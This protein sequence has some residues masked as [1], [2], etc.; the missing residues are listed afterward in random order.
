MSN[1]GEQ[2]FNEY[3]ERYFLAEI[4]KNSNLPSIALLQIIRDTGVEPAWTQI[5]LPTGRSVAACQNAYSAL[6]QR[7]SS[8]TGE[9]VHKKPRR[10]PSF[11]GPPPVTERFLQPRPAGFAPVNGPELVSLTTDETKPRKKRGRPNK[12]EHDRRVA[13]AEARGEVYPKPRKPKT[14]RPATEGQEVETV[15]VSGSGAPMAI[16]FTPNKTVPAPPT[17]P[18]PGEKMP[19]YDAIE[20]AAT[21]AGRVSHEEQRSIESAPAEPRMNN[22]G[23]GENVLPGLR[24]HTITTEG[25]DIEMD[26]SAPAAS[27]ALVPVGRV[28]GA[29]QVHPFSASTAQEPQAQLIRIEEARMQDA[30]PN[31]DLLSAQ[32][33]FPESRS[34]IS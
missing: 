17:S 32:E 24:Q 25:T 22:L 4:L 21:P 30:L 6:S 5:A 19:E 7:S 14:P 20:S 16:M 31:E 2:P 3:E 28:Y 33:H 12:E 1:F 23:P 26:P 29:Q 15:E 8:F 13:E 11:G 34:Q 10:P 9:P 27:S 18:L